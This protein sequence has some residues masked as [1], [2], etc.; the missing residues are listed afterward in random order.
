MVTS[1]PGPNEPG[2]LK[3]ISTIIVSLLTDVKWNDK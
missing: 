1:R 2:Q 3:T